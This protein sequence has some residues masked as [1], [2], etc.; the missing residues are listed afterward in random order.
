MSMLRFLLLLC[1]CSISI[2]HGERMAFQPMS[3]SG[4]SNVQSTNELMKLFKCP[5]CKRAYH[6]SL[7]IKIEFCF[8]HVLFQETRDQLSKIRCD[9]FTRVWGHE[10]V[11]TSLLEIAVSKNKNE[12]AP[13]SWGVLSTEPHSQP[14]A[15]S[16]WKAP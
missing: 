16:A 13:I 12:A 4:H 9:K 11:I 2:T 1:I 15:A 5:L 3:L 7:K 14:R 10:Y 8:H 6:E